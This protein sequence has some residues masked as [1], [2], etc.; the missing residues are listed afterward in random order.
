[1]RE[2]PLDESRTC[3]VRNSHAIAASSSQRS[4]GKTFLKAFEYAKNRD[5]RI[6]ALQTTTRERISREFP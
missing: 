3:S 6:R 1:L 5:E 4:F 2:A